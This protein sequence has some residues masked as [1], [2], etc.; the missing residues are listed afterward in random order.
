MIAWTSSHASDVGCKRRINEDA[1][2]SRPD[3]G[4]WAVADGMG[5]HAAGDVASNAIVHALTS[6]HRPSGFAD[7]IDKVEDTLIDV[8]SQLRAYSRDQLGGRTVGSTVVA[9]VLDAQVGCCLWAGDSRLYRWRD[10]VLVRLSKD[11]SAVQELVENGVISQDEAD[12]HPKSN[13]ITRAVGG[14]DELY[15]DALLFQPL[16]GD[17]YLLCSDG[18]YNEVGA[19][20]IAAALVFPV[21]QACQSLMDLA[22]ERGARDNVSLVVIGVSGVANGL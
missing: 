14:A 9:M 15:L 18:L 11:H 21:T 2:L 3:D 20:D 22:L 4:F 6:T 19:A 8:N 16:P 5:G 12:T 7:F 17:V 1:V 10:G 13:V